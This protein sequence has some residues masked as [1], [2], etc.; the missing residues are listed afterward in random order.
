MTPVGAG[1]VSAVIS[2]QLP[3]DGSGD[4]RFQRRCA[5]VN[6][7]L[8]V[9]RAGLQHNARMRSVITHPAEN[10]G[11][12]AVEIEQNVAGVAVVGVGLDEDVAALAVAH[13]EESYG[14][15]IDQLGSRPQPLAGKRSARVIVNQTDQVQ[16]VRHPRKLPTDRL[17]REHSSAIDH[18]ASMLS[19]NA[20]IKLFAAN[21]NLSLISVS[22]LRGAV[23]ASRLGGARARPCSASAVNLQ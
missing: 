20:R 5:D 8:Q 15:W 14:R 10:V 17:R 9:S 11:F 19:F 2:G 6:P 4:A 13:A 7:S 18:A 12:S 22:H 23:H 3:G 1:I 16:I 21:G